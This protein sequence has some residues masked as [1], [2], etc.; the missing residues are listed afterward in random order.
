MGI[1]TIPIFKKSNFFKAMK[2]DYYDILGVKRDASESEIKSAYRK[3]AIKNHP[4]KQQGKSDAEKKAAEERFKEAAE[5]YEVL[6]DPDKKAHYDRFGTMDGIEGGFTGMGGMDIGDIMARMHSMMGGGFDDISSFFRGGGRRTNQGPTPGKDI[7]QEIPIGVEELFNGVHKDITFS[8]QGKPCPH[9]NGSGMIT[10]TRQVGPGFI[11]Q[12]THA[13]PHCNGTGFVQDSSA[14]QETV[15]VS[16][17]A[18]MAHG[19]S[20]KIHNM[21]YD[22]T[23]GGPKGS[24]IPIAVYKFDTSKYN[25]DY[26]RHIF[27]EKISVP[28]YDCILGWEKKMKLASGKEEKVKVP[29]YNYDGELVNIGNYGPNNCPYVLVIECKMPTYVSNKERKVLE[30][31][32]KINK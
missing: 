23:N 15:Q 11:T 10:E 28:Y 4:D 13:C 3:A 25:Y 29:A 9:C 2:K 14:K 24:F 7:Q 32:Q 12:T 8:R 16:F 1:F 6:S 18:G 26:Q 19:Q 5:A 30:E 22:S 17:A 27:Y 21:G 31:L 20:Y